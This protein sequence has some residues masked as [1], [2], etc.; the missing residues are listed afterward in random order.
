[1]NLFGG[2]SDNCIKLVG[3]DL[4]PDIQT[5]NPGK[6]QKNDRCRDTPDFFLFTEHLQ[7]LLYLIL[8]MHD[9]LHRH[10]LISKG[11][12]DFRVLRFFHLQLQ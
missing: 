3:C 6:D 4:T 12:H 10:H 9:I 5:Q 11:F 8:S 1:M 7:E 2:R